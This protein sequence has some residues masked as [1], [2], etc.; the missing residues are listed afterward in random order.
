MACMP[1][2][3]ACSDI[4]VCDSCSSGS[5]LGGLC[6]ANTLSPTT[7]V[8]GQTSFSFD[9][10]EF[11]SINTH[12]NTLSATSGEACSTSFSFDAAEVGAINTHIIKELQVD[13]QSQQIALSSATLVYPDSSTKQ[14]SDLSSFTVPNY[15]VVG[16]TFFSATVKLGLA[17]NGS[18]K[19]GDLGVITLT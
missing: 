4:Y 16:V 8:P 13:P 19:E 1:S 6:L 15:P 12:I 5:L 3:S 17:V 7:G 9:A 10:S 14:I 2:C 18:S 11:T